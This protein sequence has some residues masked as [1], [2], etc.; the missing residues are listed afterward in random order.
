MHS[1]SLMSTQSSQPKSISLH[2]SFILQALLKF[3]DTKL[4]TLSL[5]KVTAD[6]I[7]RVSCDSCGS[8][9]I[10][11]FMT[12]STVCSKK[13]MKL[14]DTLKVRSLPAFCTGS[15]YFQFR[16]FSGGCYGLCHDCNLMCLCTNT[17]NPFNRGHHCQ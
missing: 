12:S 11:T 6:D 1:V 14:N 9:A 15:D 16:C 4:V 3:R 5:L 13:K 8:H 10:T 7:M 2:G 17:V